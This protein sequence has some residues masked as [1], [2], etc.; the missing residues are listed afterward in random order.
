MSP[1][2]ETEQKHKLQGLRRKETEHGQY[3][4]EVWNI[5]KGTNLRLHGIDEE[6]SNLMKLG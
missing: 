1:T 2:D 3:F 5:V 4:P 6:T